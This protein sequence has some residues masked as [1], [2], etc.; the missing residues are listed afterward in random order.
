MTE[1]SGPIPKASGGSIWGPLGG[2]FGIRLA[3]ALVLFGFA[4][5]I[6]WLGGWYFAAWIVTA[7]AVMAIEWERMTQAPFAWAGVAIPVAANA[8]AASLAVLGHYPYAFAAIGVGALASFAYAQITG[9]HRRWAFAVPLYLGVPAIALIWLRGAPDGWITT[10]WFLFVVWATDSWAMIAGR[11]FKGPLLAP[12][13]SPKKTWSGFF[14]GLVGAMGIGAIFAAVAG[15]APDP[16]LLV[17]MLVVSFVGQA[18]DVLESAIKRRFQAKDA[19]AV[20]PGHGGF[21]DRLDSLLAAT[22][23]IAVIRLIWPDFP[24]AGIWP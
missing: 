3:S 15:R 17:A 10:L 7:C 11:V 18:G 22:L 2:D 23:A 13:I 8:V 5:L 6:V 16:A 14:G 9:R 24:F 19:G 4:L 12:K 21:L 20:I 1:A